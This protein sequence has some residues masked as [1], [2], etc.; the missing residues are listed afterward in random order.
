MDVYSDINKSTNP[1]GGLWDKT[2]QIRYSTF[3]EWGETDD[4]KHIKAPDDAKQ[5]NLRTQWIGP[6]R[7]LTIADVM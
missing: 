3:S 1:Y 2:P 7:A 6:P 4:H 5:P